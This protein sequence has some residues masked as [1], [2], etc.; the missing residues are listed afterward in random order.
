[1]RERVDARI[2]AQ[3]LPSVEAAT[4]SQASA[5]RLLTSP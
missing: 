4:L 2:L 5:E 1:M 3:T